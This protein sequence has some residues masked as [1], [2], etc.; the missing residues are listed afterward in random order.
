MIYTCLFILIL[1]NLDDVEERLNK[2]TITGF[3]VL[4]HELHFIPLP[5]LNLLKYILCDYE[6]NEDIAI[7]TICKSFKDKY[8][9]FLKDNKYD[10]ITRLTLPLFYVTLIKIDGRPLKELVYFVKYIYYLKYI[11]ISVLQ[12]KMSRSAPCYDQLGCC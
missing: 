11:Y 5:Y 12:E 7:L 10:M 6:K 4:E 9:S 2:I 1:Y 3:N 8:D